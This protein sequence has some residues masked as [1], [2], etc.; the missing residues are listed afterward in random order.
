MFVLPGVGSLLVEAINTRDY[1]MVSGVNV[2]MAAF[3]L[4]ANIVIDI[5]YAWLDPRIWYQ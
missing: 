3:V 1:P 2:F 5:S 4:V